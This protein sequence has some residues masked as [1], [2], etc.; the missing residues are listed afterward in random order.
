MV[1]VS[2]RHA[3]EHQFPAAPEDGFAA[4]QWIATN[5]EELGGIRGQLAVAGWSTGANIATVVCHMARDAGGP[6]IVGQ[7]LLC[8]VTDFDFNRQSYGQIHTSVTAVGMAI[9][10]APIRE[11][12]GIALRQFFDISVPA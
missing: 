8:A 1:S 10:G 7:M 6:E 11:E 3:P 9:S 5:T 12:I 4:L 2:Y